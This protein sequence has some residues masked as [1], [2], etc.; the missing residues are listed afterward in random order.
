LKLRVKWLIII[1]LLLSV[2]GNLHNYKFFKKKMSKAIQKKKKTFLILPEPY[3]MCIASHSLPFFPLQHGGE[4]ALATCRLGLQ[5]TG[6]FALLSLWVQSSG[7]HLLD[8]LG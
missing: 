8:L 5:A 4:D 1:S 7:Q 6:C 3:S 2:I